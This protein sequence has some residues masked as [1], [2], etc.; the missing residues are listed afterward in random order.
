MDDSETQK[1]VILG[2]RKAF[3]SAPWIP[4]SQMQAHS[5]RERPLK[6]S[7]LVSKLKIPC[8]AGEEE[9]ALRSRLWDVYKATSEGVE[10]LDPPAPC[11]SYN[12]EWI[13][14]RKDV[15]DLKAPQPD[16]SDQEKFQSIQQNVDNDMTIFYLAGGAFFRAG[17][18]GARPVIKQL[19]EMSGSCAFTFQPRLAPQYTIPTILLDVLVAYF[20]L[21]APPVGSFHQPINPKNIILVGESGGSLLH[22]HL[23]QFLRAIIRS[24]GGKTPVIHLNGQHIPISMPAGCALVSPGSDLVLSL[25]SVK[26]FEKFEWLSEG[27]PWLKPNYPADQIWPTI[28]PRGDLHCDNSALCHPL[29][30]PS[31]QLDWSGMPPMWITCGEETY[32]DGIKFLVKNIQ[33]SGVP[34]TFV[35]YEFM[36]HVWNVILPHLPQSRDTMKRWGQAIREIGLDRQKESSANFV[37]L[38]K[39]EVFPMSF[40]GL[41]DIPQAEVLQRMRTARDRLA[42]FVWT[43]PEAGSSKL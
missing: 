20:Y 2:F 17:P 3:K 1:Q 23:L 40:E 27:A 26:K 30:D 37:K 11:I 38:G 39:L 35:Q 19:A 25:P 10:K 13:G 33:A 14:V 5:F 29:I 7:I 22:L 36:P 41:L 15:K 9:E 6:G 12:G 24:S 32:A 18:P 8:P 42:E 31:M 34:V 28:P 43:G 16:I 4:I 21:Q